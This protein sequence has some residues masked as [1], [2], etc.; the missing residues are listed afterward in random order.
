M[1]ASLSASPE[2]HHMEVGAG[3][4]KPRD[5]IARGKPIAYNFW[6]S[7]PINSGLSVRVYV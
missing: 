3:T 6:E 1:P 7:E 2:L 4:Q 5:T